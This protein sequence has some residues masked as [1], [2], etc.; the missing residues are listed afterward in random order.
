[1]I[2]DAS[3]NVG[4]SQSKKRSST[5]CEVKKYIDA[6]MKIIISFQSSMKQEFV[7]SNE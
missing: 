7:A 4:C 2:C 3:I 1:M 6:P 5:I